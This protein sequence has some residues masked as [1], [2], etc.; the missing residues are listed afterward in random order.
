VDNAVK[1]HL[2]TLSLEFFVPLRYLTDQQFS[3]SR[4]SCLI[5]SSLTIWR[6]AQSRKIWSNVNHQNSWCFPLNGTA[7]CPDSG[8]KAVLNIDWN[9][10]RNPIFLLDN[11]KLKILFYCQG[12]LQSK[13]GFSKNLS[14][15]TSLKMKRN[16]ICRYLS[17]LSHEIKRVPNTHDTIPLR[18]RFLTVGRNE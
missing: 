14:V 4:T 17:Y 8:A 10:R 1:K 9:W 13:P 2:Y 18:N 11:T 12:P 6:I 7:G 5:N 15:E 3:L 16:I